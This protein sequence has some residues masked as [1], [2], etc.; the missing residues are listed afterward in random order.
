MRISHKF[1]DYFCWLAFH[2]P[3][4]PFRIPKF[5]RVLKYHRLDIL[6]NYFHFRHLPRK[7]KIIQRFMQ[8]LRKYSVLTY[9]LYSFNKF[10]RYHP[11][12]RPFYRD[13]FNL[14]KDI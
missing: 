5:L 1:D 3:F 4:L 2:T 8:N 10:L 12:Y 13:Y 9:C 6:A 7:G 11:A 14:Y